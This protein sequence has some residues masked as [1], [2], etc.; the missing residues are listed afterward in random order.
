MALDSIKRESRNLLVPGILFLLL[1]L[2]ASYWDLPFNNFNY[3]YVDYALSRGF[4]TLSYDR[5]GL[6]NSSHGEPKNEIQSFLEVEALAQITKKIRAGSIPGIR[7]KP[8]K[9]VH[10]GHS[11]GSAQT[12]AL[13]A[14]YPD[15]SD[16]I[17]LTGF[18]LNTS[19]NSLFLAGAG[20]QQANLNRAIANRPGAGSNYSAGY[21]TSGNAG[22][23]EFLF[24][25]PE[26]FDPKILAF[27]EQTKQPVT[28]GELL[29]VGSVPT[30]SNFTGPVFVIDGS[31]DVPF[32]GGDCTATGGT[33]ASIPAITRVVFP[34]VKKFSA[35]IQPNTGHG[36]NFHYNATAGYKQIAD[37]LQQQGL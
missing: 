8:S 23:T 3:S 34:L 4:H 2:H 25:Y 33:A 12:Y 21:L 27:A 31:N 7:Q 10:V 28:I 20:L 1:T 37:F 36:L 26:N 5:L 29:T 32:C 11:F 16:A 14:K 19:Y 9:V 13:T 17:V 15:L 35:Y 24:L 30:S 6:G 18:S 22:N